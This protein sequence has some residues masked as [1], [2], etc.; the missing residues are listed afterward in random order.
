MKRKIKRIFFALLIGLAVYLIANISDV[1]YG[2]RQ[3]K[4]QLHIVWNA[5]PVEE[6]LKDT[7]VSASIKAKLLLIGE[8]RKYAVD[9][10]GLKP[11]KNYTTFYD[12][13]NKPVLWVL[14][15]CDPLQ[16]KPYEWKF[17]FLGNVP[18]KGFFN[19]TLAKN[20]MEDLRR[21]VLDVELSPTGGWSTLGWFKDPVLSNMLKRNE[22][23]IAELIIHELLHAT[24]YLPGSVEFNENLATFVGEQGAI[25][26]LRY[27]Y[28]PAS[29]QLQEYIYFKSDEEVFGDYMLAGSGRLD[30]LYRSFGNESYREKMR[31]KYMLILEIVQGINMLPLHYPGRYIF[32]F[33]EDHLPGNTWF[34]GF[35]R[36]RSKQGD[37]QKELDAVHGDLKKYVQSLLKK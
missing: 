21:Q 4:G 24:L 14:T 11:S 19:E 13:H 33:P 27:H 6:V 30:S 7:T 23:L 3:L 10:L 16:L 25:R 9:S 26:F 31:K 34:M 22:G 1:I 37:M 20:A 36:Y 12:Q 35:R 8:I 15:A 18:Y 28:G 5:R 29:P 2:L 32:H 17:P